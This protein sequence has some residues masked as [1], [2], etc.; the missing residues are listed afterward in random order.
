MFGQPSLELQLDGAVYAMLNK[1]IAEKTRELRQMRGE[2]LQGLNIEELQKLEKL[3]Q[4][5]LCRVLEEKEDKIV[6]EMEALKRKVTFLTTYMF[7]L[8]MQKFVMNL[9][10]GKGQLLERGQS[11]DSLVTNIS[12]MSSADLRQDSDSSCAFLTLGLAC[13]S[14]FQANGFYEFHSVCLWLCTH[15]N[16]L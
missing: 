11:S 14:H 6:N 4:G 12:S 9:S 1:E 5:S 2:D 15:S 16:A 10:A 7:R 8:F 13:Y 3:I